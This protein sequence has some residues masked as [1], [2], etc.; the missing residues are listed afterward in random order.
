MPLRANT[1]ATF[2]IIPERFFVTTVNVEPSPLIMSSSAKSISFCSSFGNA[3]PITS[4]TSP[5][6]KTCVTRATNSVTSPSF[7]WLQAEG[8]VAIES[9]S[10]NAHKSRSN[11]IFPTVAATDRIVPS[12]SKSRRVATSG[13]SKCCSTIA[14][15]RPTSSTE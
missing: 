8:P 9:A 2:E 3:P 14:D 4:R 11:L 1:P 15:K 12:S 6:S 10:V 5:P 13:R 7:Q